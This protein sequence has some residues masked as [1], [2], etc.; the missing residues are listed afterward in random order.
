MQTLREK[1]NIV[2]SPLG[3]LGPP[4]PELAG[5]IPALPVSQLPNV[6]FPLMFDDA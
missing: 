4:K 2:G 5:S 6:R 3:G 1:I